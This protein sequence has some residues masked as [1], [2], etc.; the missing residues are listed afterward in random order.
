MLKRCAIATV[1]AGVVCAGGCR[2][3]CTPDITLKQETVYQKVDINPHLLT[4]N[5]SIP[6]TNGVSPATIRKADGT[7]IKGEIRWKRASH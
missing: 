1:V 6:V 7:E 4:N 2:S 5:V 3:S